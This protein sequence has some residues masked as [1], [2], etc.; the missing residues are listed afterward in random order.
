ML[1]GKVE[2]AELNN[3][4]LE[5]IYERK[6]GKRDED[7]SLIVDRSDAKYDLKDE[8][9]LNTLANQLYEGDKNADKRKAF[10]KSIQLQIG[11]EQTA[12][13]EQ[14]E[15]AEKYPTWNPATKDFD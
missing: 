1:Y 7:G 2:S 14:A 12:I 3:G 5:F 11:V 10:K 13:G 4:V 9:Q 15:Q 6:T 8:R